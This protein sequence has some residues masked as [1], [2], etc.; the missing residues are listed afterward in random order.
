MLGLSPYC[1]TSCHL[2][3]QNSSMLHPVCTLLSVNAYTRGNAVK[4]Q[5]PILC[6]QIGIIYILEKSLFSSQKLFAKE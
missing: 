6:K 3:N 2:P 4:N 5:A 1:F